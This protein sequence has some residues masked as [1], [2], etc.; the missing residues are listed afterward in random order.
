M[1]A[2]TSAYNEHYPSPTDDRGG[3]F[4]IT[5][6]QPS[7]C[8][9]YRYSTIIPISL[10]IN[11]VHESRQ[12]DSTKLYMIAQRLRQLADEFDIELTDAFSDIVSTPT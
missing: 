2:G 8:V 11:N 1:E 5:S 3:S 9:T 6:S 4:P 12:N 10:F 7:Y